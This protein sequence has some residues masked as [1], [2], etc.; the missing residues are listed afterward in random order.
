VSDEDFNVTDGS[1]TMSY[2]DT[3][4]SDIENGTVLFQ[5]QVAA[6]ETV[7]TSQLF[8]LSSDITRSEAYRGYSEEV[9]LLLEME[10]AGANRILVAIPNPF[11]EYTTIEFQLDKAGEVLFEFYDTQGR[12]LHDMTGQFESGSGAILVEGAALDVQGVIYIKMITDKTVS[13]F[14]MIRI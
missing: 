12:L 7:E 14:K 10:E 13:D 3:E 9:P 6:L 11:V 4:I 2:A 8:S 1:I 5:L